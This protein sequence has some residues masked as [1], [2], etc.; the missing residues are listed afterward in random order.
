VDSPRSQDKGFVSQ[1]SIGSF[2]IKHTTS[3]PA[4]TQDCSFERSRKYT[5]CL[6]TPKMFKEEKLSVNASNKSVKST[7]SD[8]KN[9]E[10]TDKLTVSSRRIETQKSFELSSPLSVSYN[11]RKKE[12]DKPTALALIKITNKKRNLAF[13]LL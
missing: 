4:D 11:R 3:T 10:N 7:M 12:E 9:T 5:A 1:R 2:K 13:F 6:E 8:Y